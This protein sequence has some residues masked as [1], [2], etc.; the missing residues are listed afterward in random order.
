M[1]ESA[2]LAQNTFSLNLFSPR[3]I[4][5]K[6]FNSLRNFNVRRTSTSLRGRPT[7]NAF[8]RQANRA[9]VVM[10]Q[11]MMH[12]DHVWDDTIATHYFVS[13]P[14]LVDLTSAINL[15][16]VL[17]PKRAVMMDKIHDNCRLVP[18]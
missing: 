17:S 14:L 2:G 13:G 15:T 1:N 18:L 9:F 7:A 12:L 10:D 16:M 8:Q 5:S 3:E 11:T 4:S 6:V